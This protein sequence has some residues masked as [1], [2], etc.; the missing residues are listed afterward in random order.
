MKNGKVPTV[1]QK[2]LIKSHGLDPDNHLVVKN[3]PELL[4]I[5]SRTALKKQAVTG[6]KPRTRKLY[7][8]DI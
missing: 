3:T 4:E 8:T 5:V 6:K 1:N 2:K 7:K